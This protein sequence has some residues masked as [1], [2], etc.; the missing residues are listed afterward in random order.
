MIATTIVHRAS[1]PCVTPP[2][3][4]SARTEPF[5]CPRFHG[6]G[7]SHDISE[8][9]KTTRFHFQCCSVSI[10]YPAAFPN[11]SQRFVLGSLGFF[12]FNKRMRSNP[13]TISV[14]VL[15]IRPR[16]VTGDLTQARRLV[17]VFRTSCSGTSTRPIPLI[18]YLSRR[19]PIGSFLE[20]GS[21]FTPL[22]T[23]AFAS[24]MR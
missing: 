1:R 10:W 4:L 14:L 12:F 9:L 16:R 21:T 6:R 7:V 18:L 15:L 5:H 8:N 13:G 11:L 2:T 23:C 20:G 17:A 3:S 19:G 22:R 24:S